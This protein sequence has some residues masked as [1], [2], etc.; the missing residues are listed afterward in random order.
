[1][2]RYFHGPDCKVVGLRHQPG[3]RHWE[4]GT[5]DDEWTGEFWTRVCPDCDQP[6]NGRDRDWL[7]CAF[8]GL[9]ATEVKP[10]TVQ[11]AEVA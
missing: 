11:P 2:T 3:D 10:R 6:M 9:R 1:M 8:C 7:C 4:L 5:C